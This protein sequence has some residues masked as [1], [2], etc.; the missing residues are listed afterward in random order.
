M[1]LN[2]R[3]TQHRSPVMLELGQL[4]C[5]FAARRF[6]CRCLFHLTEIICLRLATSSTRSG[7]APIIRDVLPTVPRNTPA[8]PR[9]CPVVP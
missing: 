3:R 9:N 1:R 8:L 2:C 5:R 7:V 6:S 4:S